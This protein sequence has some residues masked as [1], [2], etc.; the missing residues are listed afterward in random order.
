MCQGY[1]SAAVS[2]PDLSWVFFS[3]CIHARFVRGILQLLYPCLIFQ[4]YASAVVSEEYHW[5]I[6]HEYSS[7]SISL[8]HLAWIQQL[9]YI[10]DKSG[11]D[12]AAQVYPWHIRHGNSTWGI[13]LTHQAAVFMPHLSE[14]CFSYCIH[15]RFV[16]GILSA[17][18]RTNEALCQLS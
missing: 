11:I 15:A 9:K 1:S 5:K 2:M 13:P 17:G 10:S 14:L 7:S 3:C 8:T 18:F 4:W 6:R 16:R 12:T